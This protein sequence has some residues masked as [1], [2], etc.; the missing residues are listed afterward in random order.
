MARKGAAFLPQ[1]N[2]DVQVYSPATEGFK[3]AWMLDV[4]LALYE[5]DIAP[6]AESE[7]RLSLCPGVGVSAQDVSSLTETD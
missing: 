6:N 1:L 2:Y 4:R 3:S 7:M 5:P